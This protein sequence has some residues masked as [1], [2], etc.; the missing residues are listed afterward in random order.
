MNKIPQQICGCTL[1]AL[2][3]DQIIEV[4]G[5][6]T[7][8]RD[9]SCDVVLQQGQASR[10]HA[11]LSPRPDGVWIEDLQSTNGT[12]INDT[13]LSGG[14]LARHGDVVRFDTMA[15]SV[16]VAGAEDADSNATMLR[17]AP[18]QRNVVAAPAKPA[19]KDQ[20]VAAKATTSP[21]PAWALDG[22]QS[23]DGTQLFSG[24][25]MMKNMD[26][27]AAAA[28]PAA[29]VTIPTLIGV[30]EAVQGM[31]FQLVAS[32]AVNQWEIG[33][34]EQCD[35]RIDAPSVSK[36]HA[37]IINEGVRW[38][39]IDLM[40]ANG[41]Y[42]NGVKGL[43]SYLKSGDSVRFGQ[44][45]CRFLLADGAGA[46]PQVEAS[47]H[48][49]PAAKMPRWQLGLISFAVTAAAVAAVMWLLGT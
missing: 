3:G 17:A 44:I 22:Q 12:F 27:L 49:A 23:V 6:L 30:S 29:A 34:A 14:V 43:T 8:G 18:T 5:E 19:P 16:S 10:R 45:E 39:L 46:Q 36:N 25:M 4:S 28:A 35:I 48:G 33:R 37:Q 47:G 15:F 42:V 2:A 32:G 21:P 11:R 9:N 20:V 24:T 38:K 40:S 1:H 26:A 41:T 31:R 13:R 7:V